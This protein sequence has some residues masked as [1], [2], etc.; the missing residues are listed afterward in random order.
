MPSANIAMSCPD[1]VVWFQSIFGADSVEWVGAVTGLWGVWLTA[2]QNLLCWP[3]GLVC[4]AC[5][6]WV[7]WQAQLYADA[8]LQVGFGI[9][10]L[11]GWAQWARGGEESG[12]RLPVTR[13][14]PA[15]RLLAL[16]AGALVSAGLGWALAKITGSWISYADAA[17]SV[18]SLIAQALQGRK[19]LECWWLWIAVN[20]NYLWIFPLKGLHLT[21]LLYAVF[22]GLAVL[23]WRSWARTEEPRP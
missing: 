12:A 14:R 1:W 22:L 16:L 21:T 7:F 2:R 23:G 6:A 20:L 17:V 8:G 18:F 4:V 11:Y 9:L 19:K 3:I 5:Y 10:I 15:E 13:L